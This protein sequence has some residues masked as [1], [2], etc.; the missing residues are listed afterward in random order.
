MTES[1]VLTVTGMKCGG[2]EDTITGRLQGVDGVVSVSASAKNN[3]IT[4]EFDREKVNPDV[5]KSVI[6]RTGFT[7]E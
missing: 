6:T 3:Q 2:C 4:V 5:I 1:V 7:V